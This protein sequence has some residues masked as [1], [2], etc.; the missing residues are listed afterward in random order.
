[1]NSFF[2]A[3]IIGLLGSAHC[4]GMCSGIASAITFSI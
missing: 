1:M 3:I 2:G 4:L